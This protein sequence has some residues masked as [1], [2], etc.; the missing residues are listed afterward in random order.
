MDYSSQ[1]IVNLLS[2]N[3]MLLSSYPIGY[4]N[5]LQ[6]ENESMKD[7]I[8]HLRESN[9]NLRKRNF[10]YRDELDQ[11]KKRK[12]ERERE[13]DPI[14][15]V[16]FRKNKDSLNDEEISRLISNIKNL[17]DMENLNEKYR[18]VRHNE[19]LY[20]MCN[21]HGPLKKINNM[22]GLESVKKEIF[23]KIIYYLKNPNNEEYLHTVL[24]GPPGV[25][26]TEL[27]KIYGEIFSKLGILKTNKFTQIKR[28]N[29]VAEYLGQ[30]SHRTKK[31]L[32]EAMGGVLFLDEAYSLGN[33]E[34]RDSFAKE[35]IDMI[36]QYLSERKND[37]MFVIAGYEKELDDC[38][39]SINPGLKRR[40]ST[41]FNIDKYS[42]DELSEIFK[43]KIRESKYEL[44]V[45]DN[46]LKD[47]FKINM[48]K[49]ENYAGDVEKLIN[50]MKY[51][52]SYRTFSENI[53]SK[54]MIFKDLINSVKIF[55]EKEDKSYL[56]N[57]YI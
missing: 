55:K 12:R 21:L 54:K 57:L 39:F 20:K 6:N 3:M 41:F 53:N 36:N 31:L 42:S 50:E 49:F 5:K 29:L 52:Q 34:K 25:G 43:S 17:K 32:E 23:K 19:M 9:S 11:V 8:N 10:D 46:E 45:K 2:S 30:T 18:S 14:R 44:D 35:A 38:F 48:D 26:K 22:V 4:V 16:K 15:V 37:F 47:F 24:S 28:D 51:C 13:E 56:N 7:E 40:F 27:A 1:E 33:R